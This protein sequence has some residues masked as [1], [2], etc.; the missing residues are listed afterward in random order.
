MKHLQLLR[1]TKKKKESQQRRKKF[2]S[3]HSACASHVPQKTWM[4]QMK[5]NVSFLDFLSLK[6]GFSFELWAE[7]RFKNIQ[8]AH[9]WEDFLLPY[10]W[11]LSNEFSFFEAQ[12]SSLTFK[13]KAWAAISF[14]RILISQGES[15]LMLTDFSFPEQRFPKHSPSLIEEALISFWWAALLA[16]QIKITNWTNILRMQTIFITS[17]APSFPRTL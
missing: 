9:S 15:F 16:W 1:R 7:K 12:F 5:R 3:A 13:V 4:C 2:L 11:L 14:P 17:K 10:F 6:I 8:V